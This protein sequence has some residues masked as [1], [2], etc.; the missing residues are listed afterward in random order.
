MHLIPLVV[1]FNLMGSFKIISF[2]NFNYKYQNYEQ[3]PS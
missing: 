3:T 1:I 2:K